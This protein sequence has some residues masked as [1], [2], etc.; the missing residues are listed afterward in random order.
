MLYGRYVDYSNLLPGDIAV[1]RTGR[2]SGH[3]VMYIG[4]GRIV[5]MPYAGKR[6]QIRNLLPAYGSLIDYRKYW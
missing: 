3:V 6:C 5:E 4:S 1:Y 2:D